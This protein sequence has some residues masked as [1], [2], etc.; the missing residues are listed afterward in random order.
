VSFFSKDGSLIASRQLLIPAPPYSIT[1][2]AAGLAVQV[3]LYNPE[4][5]G[6]NT[7]FLFD[8]RG[9]GIG[10]GCELPAEYPNSFRRDRMLGHAQFGAV[11]ALKDEL[12]CSFAGTPVIQV[13][14][15]LGRSI[16]QLRVAPPIYEAPPDAPFDMN[17]QATLHFLASYTAHADFYPFDSGFVSFYS[18]FDWGSQR[19]RYWAF[20]CRVS[21]T[22]QARCGL[23]NLPGKPILAIAL[24]SVL[25]SDDTVAAASKLPLSIL[26]LEAHP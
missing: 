26:T 19:F 9:H 7:V 12:F 8:R 3:T 14:D 5:D 25:V 15:T 18:R 2:Y 21:P 17:R 6:W 22:T 24:D 13:M 4:E 23:A 20:V 1:G 11:R 16:R 10:Q